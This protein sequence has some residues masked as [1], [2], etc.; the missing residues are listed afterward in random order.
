MPPCEDQSDLRIRRERRASAALD[1]RGRQRPRSIGELAS[2]EDLVWGQASFTPEAQSGS[3]E[4]PFEFD[5]ASLAGSD[6]VVIE[7]L[8]KEDEGTQKLVADT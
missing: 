1:D 6:L 2:D 8:V 3:I 5:S 7:M 4:V